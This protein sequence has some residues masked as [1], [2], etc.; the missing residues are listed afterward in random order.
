MSGFPPDTFDQDELPPPYYPEAVPPPSVPSLFSPHLASLPSRILAAQSVRTAAR[1]QC[2]SEI[3]AL[4]VPHIESL[5]SF[6]STANHSP[7]L[8]E[9]TI[10]PEDAVSTDWGLTDAARRLDGELRRVVRVRKNKKPEKGE[11]EQDKVYG[12]D[13]QQANNQERESDDW[14]RWDYDYGD[15]TSR[16]EAFLW[17]SDEDMARRLAKYLQPEASGRQVNRQDVQAHMEQAKQ[18]RKS[19]RWSFLRKRDPSP[20]PSPPTLPSPRTPALEDV[21]KVTM[22]VTSEEVTFRRENEFGIWESKR[23]W[24]IVLR[25]S[26]RQ[27]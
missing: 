20:A 5:F 6:L 17:W 19:G 4:I 11:K 25:V 13:Y 16:S 8:V 14:G 27:P 22:N 1:D 10:V 26:I 9:L 23:G 3:L 2:D 12:N 15:S 7:S 18:G 21:D 24:G